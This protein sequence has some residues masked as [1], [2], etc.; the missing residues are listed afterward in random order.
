VSS[1]VLFAIGAIIPVA[2]FFLLSGTL[3]VVLSVVLSAGGLFAI[4][5][6]ITLLTGQSVLFSGMRQ[7]L[8]ELAAA[9]LTY[10]V[11]LLIGTAASG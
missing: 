3:A 9:A 7:V 11:G 2:P 8:V 4:G 10:K 1:F 5:A 6:L